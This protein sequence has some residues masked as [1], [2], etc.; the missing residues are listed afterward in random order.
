MINP[1]ELE[2][3]AISA[4]INAYLIEESDSSITNTYLTPW[5]AAAFH[6]FN[7]SHRRGILGWTGKLHRE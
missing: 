4:A 2:I 5:K 1:T 6:N 3:A 7:I